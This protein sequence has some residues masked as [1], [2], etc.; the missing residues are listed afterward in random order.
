MDTFRL[1]ETAANKTENH[2]Y[3]I[4]T[5]KGGTISGNLILKSALNLSDATVTGP[6]RIKSSTDVALD[7]LGSIV[8]GP[9]NGQQIRIDNNEIASVDYDSKTSAYISS[10]LYLNIEEGGAVS[11]G[12]GKNGVVN[13]GTGTNGK[14]TIG[15]IDSALVPSKTNNYNLGTNSVRWNDIFLSD[16][17]YCGALIVGK[18]SDD[19]VSATGYGTAAPSS[20]VGTPLVGRV[21]F[22]VI[23]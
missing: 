4:I 20:A 9:D 2:S 1:P 13:I 14:T 8:I 3:N 23:S 7:K 17:C 12:T 11:I 18:S 22:K 16:Y 10:T 15:S 6:I 21:Y 19:Y 5:S